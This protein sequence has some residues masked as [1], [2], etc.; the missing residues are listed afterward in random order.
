MYLKVHIMYK[1]FYKGSRGSIKVRVPNRC[2][3]S[4]F[5]TKCFQQDISCS[6]QAL[7]QTSFKV[8]RNNFVE[9]CRW[10]MNLNE[11]LTNISLIIN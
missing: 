1:K 9:I 10:K 6:M 7:Q 8:V 11:G 4:M 2:I 3:F 5:A